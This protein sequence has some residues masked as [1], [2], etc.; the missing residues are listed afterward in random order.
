MAPW[1]AFAS[2]PFGRRVRE[3]ARVEYLR[4]SAAAP[5]RP[6]APP[7]GLR[8]RFPY[9]LLRPSPYSFSAPRRSRRT[10]LDEPC[11]RAR[12]SRGFASRP[13]CS[14][15]APQARSD[16]DDRCLRAAKRSIV[17]ASHAGICLA[18]TAS[19]LVIVS[20]SS[21]VLA[22]RGLLRSRPHPACGAPELAEIDAPGKELEHH[23]FAT[24][25]VP[26]SPRRAPGCTPA[27]RA[28]NPRTRVMRTAAR[29]RR[30]A[31]RRRSARQHDHGSESLADGFAQSFS[32]HGR[33]KTEK[34]SFSAPSRTCAARRA[35][36]AAE[37]GARRGRRALRRAD[38]QRCAFT[39][40]SPTMLCI[41]HSIARAAGRAGA[42]RIASRSRAAAGDRAGPPRR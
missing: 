11:L 25:H 12:T 36:D 39:A 2:L 27:S 5:E 14:S 3:L 28:R 32:S 35:P 23:E 17:A 16:A 10:S 37:S 9:P 18:S 34:T 21:P 42:C 6:R 24:R 29:A 41:L 4:R 7:P 30:S 31:G 15:R 38:A 13:T 40:S 26:R 33:S 19:L 22:R 8:N 20:A 1:I